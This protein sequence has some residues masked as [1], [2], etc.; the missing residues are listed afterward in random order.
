[1]SAVPDNLSMGLKTMTFLAPLN[2]SDIQTLV[3]S[4][5]DAYR[6]TASA[7][8]SQ[9]VRF[10]G[11]LLERQALGQFA[12]KHP[13]A[14]GALQKATY[15]ILD[16]AVTALAG[17]PR[18]P[19]TAEILKLYYFDR[20]SDQKIANALHSPNYSRQSVNRYRKEGIYEV[21]RVIYEQ[22]AQLREFKVGELEL[23]LSPR[24]ESTLFVGREDAASRLTA[25]LL[26]PSSNQLIALV[27]LDGIGKTTLATEASKSALRELR[28][29]HV[30]WITIDGAD[31]Y[32]ASL[33]ADAD[34]HQFVRVIGEHCGIHDAAKLPARTCLRL[35][36]EYLALTPVLVILDNF[37]LTAA[38]EHLLTHLRALIGPGK[39]LITCDA[40]PSP[41]LAAVIVV[42]DALPRAASLT[43]LRHY[44][45]KSNWDQVD[46]AY[47]ENILAAVGGH[48]QALIMLAAE[49]RPV[50]WIRQDLR[51]PKRLTLQAIYRRIYAAKW[52]RL[53][54]KAQLLLLAIVQLAPGI[55]SHQQLIALSGLPEPEAWEAVKS[56]LDAALLV[57]VRRS[58]NV[59]FKVH[60]LTASFVDSWWHRLPLA[61]KARLSERR[62]ISVQKNLEYWQI[63]AEG[64]SAAALSKLRASLI[65]AIDAGIKEA[66]TQTQASRFLLSLFSRLSQS[67]YWQAWIPVFKLASETI[68]PDEPVVKWQLLDRLGWLY[69]MARS[70]PEAA[71]AQEAALSIARTIDDAPAAIARISFGLA[72]TYYVQRA[73]AHAWQTAVAVLEESTSLT[74]GPSHF[75]AIHNLLGL[76]GLSSGDLKAAERNL[77]TALDYAQSAASKMDEIN[78]LNNLIRVE[79]ALGKFDAAEA[80]HRLAVELVDEYGTEMAGITLANTGCALFLEM[81]NLGRAEQALQRVAPVFLESSNNSY[82]QALT[83]YNQGILQLRQQ[84]FDLATAE[85]R[86][87]AM[88]WT[89][90]DDALMV[91]CCGVYAALAANRGRPDDS[92]ALQQ[93][94]QELSRFSDSYLARRLLRRY[95]TKDM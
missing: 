34:L 40:R 32:V 39:L 91:A 7:E 8:S 2:L 90:Q 14:P 82:L 70:L 46:D 69:Q 16:Q 20:L 43:L 31:P 4:A 54:L 50:A 27:G 86:R 77:R 61:E 81:G 62:Q 76:I 21:A 11:F 84:R 67:G 89:E 36:R 87:S 22:E 51:E 52:E 75:V 28:F 42:L 79:S 64:M 13:S 59:E 65:R 18:L 48:P 68:A 85:L 5:L 78:V 73:Y 25:M 53:P 19:F 80:N 63:Q 38:A 30:V 47:L 49:S 56:L 12:Q 33:P 92:E 6:A 10:E 83:S 23:S 71:Q 88:L 9:V 55:G 37:P 45:A 60:Q 1:M 44:W 41:R 35:V 74:L 93:A 29:E 58:E 95:S 57:T 15:H 24:A 17:E 94:L 3:N 66:S 72:G 26:G